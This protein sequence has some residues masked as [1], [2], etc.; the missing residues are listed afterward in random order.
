MIYAILLIIALLVVVLLVVA[1]RKPNTFRIARS[2]TVNA[3]AKAVYAQI[4]DF[5]RWQ[6]WSPFEKLDSSMKKTFGDVEGGV[7]AV[8]SWDGNS[9]AGAGRMEIVEAVPPN[10]V[11]LD[12][13]FTR[14]FKAANVTEFTMQPTVD[15]THVTWTMRGTNSFVQKLMCIF[16]SMDRLIG[17]DFEE[18]LANLKRNAE[19]E[20]HPSPAGSR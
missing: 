17:K 6:T 7:G 5:H 12:L 20:S 19:R 10:R 1:A 9:R 4:I 18:G 2:T 14:P 11:T 3:P 16:V 15:G 8:Y 13:A